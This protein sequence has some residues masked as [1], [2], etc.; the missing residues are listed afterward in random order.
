MTGAAFMSMAPRYSWR[1]RDRVIETGMRPVVMG[2]LNVTPD[3][4]SDGGAF[5]TLEAAVVRGRKMAEEGA[6]I[7]DVGG[8]STRP[9]AQAVSAGEEIARIIPVIRALVAAFAAQS[10]APV[11]SVDTRKA[12][13]AEAAME[14][15]ARIINDVT[16]LEGDP[17][18]AD[19]ARRY[20]AGVVLMHMK[21]DPATMQQDPRYGDVVAEVTSGLAARIDALNKAG[22]LADTMVVDPGI[23]FGKT[24]D[25]NVT[26]LAGL[27]RLAALG[28]PVLVGVS[29]KKFIGDIT[30]RDVAHRQAGSLACAVW[31]ATRGGLIWRVHD[32]GESVDAARMVAVMNRETVAWSGSTR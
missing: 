2:I 14:A 22:L 26:L 28:R 27:G 19:V 23:G 21:G 9:G 11:V 8:E 31:A 29:R 6:D 30:G 12:V 5:Q 1:C 32:V 17:Q 13:V 25:H 10:G 24:A 3:S 20:G 15:G 16:A 18:M 7:V 4:F